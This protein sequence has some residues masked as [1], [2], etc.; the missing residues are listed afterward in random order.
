MPGSITVNLPPASQATVSAGGP[1]DG[2]GRGFLSTLSRPMGLLVEPRGYETEATFE[3]QF[4]FTT[5]P[6]SP[7]E[8]RKALNRWHATVATEVMRSF[9]VGSPD[10][11]AAPC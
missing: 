10:R 7:E 2:L 3:Q 6:R 11:P 5:P 8:R 9:P 4:R 1:R